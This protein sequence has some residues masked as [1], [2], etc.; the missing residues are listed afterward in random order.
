MSTRLELLTACP[1]EEL[2]QFPT[3]LYGDRIIPAT[4]FEMER[5]L[6]D[7]ALMTSRPGAAV[8][9]YVVSNGSDI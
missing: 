4:V 9:R 6:R 7:R 2:H 8:A 3:G 1:H 5:A